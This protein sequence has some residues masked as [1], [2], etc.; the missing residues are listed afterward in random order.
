MGFLPLRVGA[1]IGD[2]AR[3]EIDRDAA[4]VFGRGVQIG[5]RLDIG[6]RVAHRRVHR[7]VVE[8]ACPSS[9]CSALS[10]R[11]GKSVAAPTP[12]AMRL[13]FAV[14]AELDLRRRRHEGEIAAP[15]IHLVKA[16]ADFA[17]PDR[18]AHA[19]RGRRRPAAW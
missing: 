10:S 6:E 7:L 12:M 4:A 13:A 3:G 15:R 19:R 2:R 16:D 11:M 18:K 14:V 1:R 8:R 17:E 5:E 9:C